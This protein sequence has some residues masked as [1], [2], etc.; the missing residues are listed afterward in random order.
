MKTVVYGQDQRVAKWVGARVDEPNFGDCVGI[1]LEENG[2]L[3]AGVV[4]NIF[5]GPSICAHIAAMPGKRWMTRDFLWRIH[6]YPFLQL[7]CNRITALVRQDNLVSQ[8]FVE[9]LGFRYEGVMRQACTDGQ[10]MFIYGML[11]KECRWLEIK[12]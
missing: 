6:A 1:G 2:E 9:H 12:R 8:H 4:Y 11:R 7:K 10:N 3:I 5:S